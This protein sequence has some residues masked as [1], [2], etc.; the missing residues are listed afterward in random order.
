MFSA[1]VGTQ[2]DYYHKLVEYALV[3]ARPTARK[4]ISNVLC[5][6][7]FSS[8]FRNTAWTIAMVAEKESNVLGSNDRIREHAIE[9]LQVQL[10]VNSLGRTHGILFDPRD[11]TFSF[12]T[13]NWLHQRHWIKIDRTILRSSRP[14]LAGRGHGTSS[15][16]QPFRHPSCTVSETSR[17]HHHPYRG[18]PCASRFLRN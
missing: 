4:T 15:H 16:T 14:G 11:Q 5:S 10:D 18:Q 12:A 7:A 6:E 2:K 13:A 17:V 9:F 1:A 3:Q 8:R